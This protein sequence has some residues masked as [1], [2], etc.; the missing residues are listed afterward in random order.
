ML[1]TYLLGEIVYETK[2]KVFFKKK[3]FISFNLALLFY[4]I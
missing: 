3:K 4:E 1:T 2:H